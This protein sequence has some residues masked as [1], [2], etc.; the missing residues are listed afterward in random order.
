[1]AVGGFG[2]GFRGRSHAKETVPMDAVGHA[3]QRSQLELE[4]GFA[5]TEGAWFGWVLTEVRAGRGQLGHA[6]Q[7]ETLGLGGSRG[8][9]LTSFRRYLPMTS[10]AG[11]NA[12]YRVDFPVV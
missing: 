4:Q 1:M 11:T 9:L 12:C 3:W 5:G 10:V 6:W 2:Q 8:Q 7:S